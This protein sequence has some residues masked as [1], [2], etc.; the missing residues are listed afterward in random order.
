MQIKG[1]FVPQMQIFFFCTAF[2]CPFFI[3]I[4]PYVLRCS[5]SLSGRLSLR[6]SCLYVDDGDDPVDDRSGCRIRTIACL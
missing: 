1:I 5:L 4:R 6:K 3:F 2:P